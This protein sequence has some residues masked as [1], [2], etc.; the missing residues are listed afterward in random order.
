VSSSSGHSSVGG[1]AEE[2]EAIVKSR[3]AKD[4]FPGVDE[5]KLMRKIDTRVVPILCLLY[6][7]AFLDR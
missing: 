3:T 2:R 7:L 4:I 5:T 6:L 1:N